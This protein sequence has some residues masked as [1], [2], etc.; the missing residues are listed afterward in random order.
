[1]ALANSQI[2]ALAEVVSGWT[3][4]VSVTVGATTATYTPS[5]R[6]SAFE[7]LRGIGREAVRVHG[8]TVGGWATSAGVL[9]VQ[10]SMLFDIS[11]TGTTMGRLGLTGT[12][13]GSNEYTFP[14]A[15][16][17]AVVPDYGANA[18]SAM[19]QVKPGKASATGAGALTAGL[20]AAGGRI[21]LFDDLSDVVDIAAELDAGGTYDA[22]VFSS[23]D[24]MPLVRLR[25]K[26]VQIVRWG[27]LA[28]NA[29][30]V[31]RC[32]EVRA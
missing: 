23:D 20:E 22:A 10:A 8:G 18:R 32:V 25:V 1:M 28:S 13:S 12:L 31:A 30:T 4:A 2:S 16:I 24:E 26:G 29:R 5:G 27:M 7:V 15:Y 21:S 14:S 9:Q 6:T 11:A 17:G 19:V 3:G